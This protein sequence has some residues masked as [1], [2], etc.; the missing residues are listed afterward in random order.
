MIVS[1]V[2][3]IWDDLAAWKILL[4]GVVVICL[5][6]LQL[7][8]MSQHRE[9]CINNSLQRLHLN[10][11]SRTYFFTSHSSAQSDFAPIG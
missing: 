1:A 6:F 8:Q 5:Q 9:V 4:Q 3:C 7:P 11:N 10:P 2:Y